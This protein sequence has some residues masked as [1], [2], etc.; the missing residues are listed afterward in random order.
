MLPFL[1][2][3]VFPNDLLPYLA[4]YLK[5]HK[6]ATGSDPKLT[7]ALKKYSP[8]T[9]KVCIFELK[10]ETTFKS[11]HIAILFKKTIPT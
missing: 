8:T 11:K 3:D 5:N 1:N 7:Y 9:D 10:K 6:A 4:Q 2:N